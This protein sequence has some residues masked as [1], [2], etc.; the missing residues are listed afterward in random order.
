MGPWEAL[1]AFLFGCT[2]FMVMLLAH[3]LIKAAHVRVQYRHVNERVLT[4]IH[5]L[6]NNKNEGMLLEHELATLLSEMPVDRARWIVQ[7]KAIADSVPPLVL[8]QMQR[9]GLAELPPEAPPTPVRAPASASVEPPPAADEPGASVTP[10]D[11]W[12]GRERTG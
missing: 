1:L 10:I 5:Q 3:R 9:F 2:G 4:I 11:A 6:V 8:Q 12:T 7:M